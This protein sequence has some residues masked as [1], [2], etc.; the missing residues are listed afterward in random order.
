VP[1]EGATIF[2]GGMQRFW[3]RRAAFNWDIARLHSD[4]GRSAQATWAETYG[5]R[6]LGLALTEQPEF[7]DDVAA[8]RAGTPAGDVARR[9]VRRDQARR[10]ETVAAYLERAANVTPSA[11]HRFEKAAVWNTGRR[12]WTVDGQLEPGQ[13]RRNLQTDTIETIDL[14]AL[15]VARRGAGRCADPS[16]C[17]GEGARLA[18]DNRNGLCGPCAA[19]P[20]RPRE[21]DDAERALFDAATPVVLPGAPDRQRARRVHRAS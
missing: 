14:G 6:A 17:G 19:K 7:W 15:R 8:I 13:P 10:V 4:E 21:M 1:S 5:A 12:A 3:N 9:Y 2:V 18:A 20:R 11:D 16:C